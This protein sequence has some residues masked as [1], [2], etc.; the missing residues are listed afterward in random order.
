MRLLDDSSRFNRYKTMT[1]NRIA[2]GNSASIY[3]AYRTMVK[4]VTEEIE[5]YLF[6]AIYNAKSFNAENYVSDL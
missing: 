6:G 2:S 4:K 3:V 5:G 1:G